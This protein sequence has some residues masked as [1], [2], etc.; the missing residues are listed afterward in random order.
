M[1]VQEYVTDIANEQVQISDKLDELNEKLY[2]K[3]HEVEEEVDE[4][5]PPPVD[6]R[7]DFLVPTKPLAVPNHGRFRHG[8]PDTL[9][10]HGLNKVLFH[11]LIA[12][13]QPPKAMA[14]LDKVPEALE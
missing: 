11:V 14:L 12:H 6:H 1:L 3:V 4:K 13:V 2:V 9:G 7:T 5:L 10:T 8:Q